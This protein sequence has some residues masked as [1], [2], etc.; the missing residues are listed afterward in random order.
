M[1]TRSLLATVLTSLSPRGASAVFSELDTAQSSTPAL[2]AAVSAPLPG[3][4]DVCAGM[5]LQCSP[6]ICALA[7]RTTVRLEAKTYYQNRSIVLPEGANVIGAGINKTIIVACGAPSSGRRGF[8]LGNHSY[9]GHYTWQGLQASRGNFDAAIQTPGCL[10][11]D[12]PG[13]MACYG[14][15][16][17]PSCIP[18]GGDCAGV[19]NATAEHIHVRPYARGD[20]WWPL[21]SSAGWFP[22]TLP[23]GPQRHTGSHHITLRGIINWGTWA[24]GIN[25]HGGHH[26]VL[27]EG[28]GTLGSLL[29]IPSI[30]PAV[31]P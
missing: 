15:N 5:D 13:P 23:W 26:D 31:D 24:D 28:C 29:S 16:G 20:A 6:E 18:E 2:P 21:S 27:V 7:P 3:L 14:T 17:T 9:L 30:I 25:L 4:A 22:H 11:H 19:H 12:E 1:T 8:V 10:N